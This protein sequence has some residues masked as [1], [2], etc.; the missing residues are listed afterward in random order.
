MMSAIYA[1]CNILDS[2]SSYVLASKALAMFNLYEL[3][4]RYIFVLK[5]LGALDEKLLVSIYG[6]G[7]VIAHVCLI[8]IPLVRIVV[9]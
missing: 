4:S 3:A 1:S 2:L 9:L 8:M 7:L 5:T 6:D